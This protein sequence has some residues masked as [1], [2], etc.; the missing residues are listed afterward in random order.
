MPARSRSGSSALPRLALFTLEAL[1]NARAVRRLVEARAG[2]IA[3]VVL[4]NPYRPKMGGSL[5]QLRRHMARSGVAFLPYLTL[6]FTLVELS[7]L[8]APLGRRDRPL[9]AQPLAE[10]CRRLAIPTLTVDDVNA[11]DIVA[12]LKDSGA[13]LAL[14]FHFDQIF[15][16]ETLAAFPQGGVNVH[17]SLLPDHRGPTPTI[18]ALAEEPPRFGV[19]VHRLAATID[20]GDV[21]AQRAVA[22]PA[23]T[24][25]VRAASALHEEGRLLLD[26][27]LSDWPGSARP[28]G[29]ARPYC[30]FPDPGMLRA[31]RR[32]GRSL[33]DWRDLVNAL[34][35]SLA[36]EDDP[37][38]ARRA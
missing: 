4:S 22:L 27:V 26:G 18:H 11:P 34:A 30:P 31:M 28:Q 2:E 10:V 8:L 15:R 33:T 1:S 9:E 17:P 7:N 20:T 32:R 16:P 19:T 35:V 21:L 6:N 3:L 36:A 24:T 25:A 14:S 23:G 13:E 12:R 29:E 37:V 38:S 5:G